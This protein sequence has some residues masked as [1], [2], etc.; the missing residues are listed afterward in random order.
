MPRRPAGDA[1]CQRGYMVLELR[2]I[3]S[4]RFARARPRAGRRGGSNLGI[5]SLVPENGRFRWVNAEIQIRTARME[6]SGLT[7][8]KA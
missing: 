5:P 6:E 3:R 8:L 1:L 4:R 2:Y 7:P